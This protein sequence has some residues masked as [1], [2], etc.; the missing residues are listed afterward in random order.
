MQGTREDAIEA[1]I[2]VWLKHPTRWCLNCEQDFDPIIV[3][4]GCCDK[5]YYTTNGLIFKKFI[6]EMEEIRDSQKDKFASTG[7]SNTRMRYLLR[8]PPGLL[9]FL[10]ISMKRLYEEK[11]FTKEYNQQWFAKK[12]NKHFCVAQEI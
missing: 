1:I 4:F 7:D 10:E 9:Q 8:F 2:N 11:L 6:K 5:P 3:R 12:F